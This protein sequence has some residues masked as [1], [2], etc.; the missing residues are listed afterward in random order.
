MAIKVRREDDALSDAIYSME[1]KIIE[2]LP[3]FDEADL[4]M[5]VGMSDGRIVMRANPFVQEFRALVKDYSIALKAQ[6]ELTGAE[7]QEQAAK[8]DM[9]R[10]RLRVTA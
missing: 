9:I 7:D 2:M 5:R 6:K 1:R 3:E 10:A 4:V 8:L